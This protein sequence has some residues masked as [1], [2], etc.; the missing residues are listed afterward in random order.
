MT[1][2]YWDSPEP[3][4]LYRIRSLEIDVQ[5][6]GKNFDLELYY[7]AKGT[8]MGTFSIYVEGNIENIVIKWH[9]K[10]KKVKSTFFLISRTQ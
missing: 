7:Y 8:G 4:S 10:L 3:D 2:L 9:M 6:H 5:L 1:K